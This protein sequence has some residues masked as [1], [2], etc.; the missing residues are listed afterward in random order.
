MVTFIKRNIFYKVGFLL[1]IISCLLVISNQVLV[2]EKIITEEKIIDNIINTDNK[3]VNNYKSNYVAVL[4]I[5]KISL[6]KGLV[7]INS[8]Y[9]DVD[10]NIQII[11][12]DI[13]NI[14]KE[15][16]ILAA[17]SGSGYKAFFKDLYKLEINDLAS[18]YYNS[19]KYNYFV[20]DIYTELKDSDIEIPVSNNLLILTTCY[21]KDEQ[22][23]VILEK[24]YEGFS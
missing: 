18:I 6:K 16:I 13:A 5:P 24:D 1:I 19:K 7:D 3:K 11:S 20:T 8:K 14:E 4:E 10:K 21:G 12:S 22:L 15:S 9:N 17:H 23:V 2:I